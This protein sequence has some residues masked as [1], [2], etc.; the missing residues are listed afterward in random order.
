MTRVVNFHGGP[1]AGKSTVKAGVFY[2]LKIAGYRVA[3]VE[4]YATELSVEAAWDKLTDQRGV[5]ME[6]N[7]RLRRWV[8]KVDFILSDSPLILSSLYAPTEFDTPGFH[9]LVRQT[10]DSYDN[11]NVWLRRPQSAYQLYGRHHSEAEAIQLDARLRNLLG[12]GFIDFEEQAHEN[13]HKAVAD[14]LRS[15]TR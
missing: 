12:E 1:G 8:G 7:A 2:L 5:L 9:T 13:T 14:Y 3:Q 15:L 4:E 6:Q 11:V 10:F